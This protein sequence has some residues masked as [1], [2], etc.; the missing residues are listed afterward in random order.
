MIGIVLSLLPVFALIAL[1]AAVAR[2]PLLKAEGWAA[3]ERVNY[4][5]LFP[6]LLFESIVSAELKSGEAG[7]LALALIIADL[8]IAGGVFLSRPVLKLSGPAF[9]SVLQGSIRWNGYVGLGIVAAVLGNEG[10]GFGA[11]AAAVVVPLNNIMCVYALSRFAGAEP[12]SL[13]QTLR[14]LAMNPL[15]LATLS[16]GL[17]LV[18]GLHPPQTAIDILR[19]LG[20]ATIALGLLCVGAAIDLPQLRTSGVTVAGTAVVKLMLMPAVAFAA[21]LLLGLTGAPVIAAV[22]CMATP[23]A[24]SAYI[25]ARVMGGDAPLAANIVTATTLASL[26]TLPIAIALATAWS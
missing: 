8:V 9:T 10:L 2:T 14:N 26:V 19:L 12:A 5:V 11:V 6:A 1:G 4:W 3:L 13:G 23:A 25:L 22:V 18:L 21:C 16:G 15:I 24:T 17:C 7:R 20:Q